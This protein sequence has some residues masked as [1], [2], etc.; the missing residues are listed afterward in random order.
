MILLQR[1]TRV[2]HQIKKK[3][4]ESSQINQSNQLIKKKK[5]SKN[6]PHNP[7]IMPSTRSKLS[8]KAWF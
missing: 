5:K 1:K 8:Q 2:A 4:R 3:K 7:R 6:R